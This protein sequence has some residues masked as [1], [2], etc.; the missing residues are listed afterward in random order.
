MRTF[1]SF[2]FL[3]LVSQAAAQR[4]CA[5]QAYTEAQR[6]NTQVATRLAAADAFVKSQSR[7]FVTGI[8]GN[9]SESNAAGIIRIPVV[10][11]V[12]YNTASQN[13]SDAQIQSGLAALNRD[14]RKLNSDTVNTPLRFKAAGA[15]AGIEFHLATADLNG[16]ATTGIVRK[17]TAV[18]AFDMDDKIKFSA[19]GGDDAWDSRFYL[20]IWIGNTRRLLGYATMPGSDAPLDG[21]VINFTAFGTINTA[22]PYHLGRT[23]VHEVGHWLGLYHLWG[24]AACGDDAV[25]TLR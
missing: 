11:H 4:P 25:S 21:V 17:Q 10:V 14:F 15:D 23:A 13:I 22:A 5:T 18:P 24:D 12:L 6:R 9:G 2:I 20:N 8:S 7:H 19:Q 16:V 3:T 1:A